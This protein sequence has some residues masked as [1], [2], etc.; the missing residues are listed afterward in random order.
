M[1]SLIA[2]VDREW[3]I[4]KNNKLPWRLPADLA[5]FKDM[6]HGK[7][8]IMGYNTYIS[9]GKPLEGRDNIVLTKNHTEIEGVSV[10]SSLES[11][12]ALAEGYP[13]IMIIGGSVVYKAAFPL[14]ERLY[15]THVP[16]TFYC[17]VFFPS[18]NIEEWECYS[19]PTTADN[20]APFD[21][22]F[23]IYNRSKK[24]ELRLY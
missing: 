8:C 15:I 14:A 12:I 22:T 18:F 13:E 5:Y 16:C 1:I 17:D 24:Y 2:A 3:G 4:G 6:T 11:A 9:L 10:A 21:L 19:K 7:P 20:N 23:S